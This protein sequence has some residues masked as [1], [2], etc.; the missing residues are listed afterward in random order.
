M[1]RAPLCPV[2]GKPMV[3]G[4]RPLELSYKG[5]SVTVEMPGW[6]CDESNESVHAAEDMKVSDT[7]LILLRHNRPIPSS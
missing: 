3:R 6:Y 5:Q 2:T 1:P 4:T 7:A